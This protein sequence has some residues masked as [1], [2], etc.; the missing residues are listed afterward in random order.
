MNLTIKELSKAVSYAAML[1]KNRADVRSGIVTEAQALKKAK[2]L[3]A[4][5][6]L[7][8][9]YITDADLTT[10][11]TIDTNEDPYQ[12]HS[13]YFVVE[14][15]IDSEW[16]IQAVARL[17]H[18][19]PEKQDSSFQTLVH[20]DVNKES[21]ELIQ[22]VGLENCFEVSGLVKETGESTLA[23]MFLYREMWQYALMNGQK[24][25]LM[26]CDAG[27]YKRLSFLFGNAFQQIGKKSFFKGHD[28]IPALL[29]IRGSISVFTGKTKSRN[30]ATK[31][32]QHRLANFF[33]SG[34]PTE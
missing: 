34:L 3:H 30:P 19:H 11:G 24:L 22:L 10:E 28:V 31:L 26:S 16:R 21:R 2:Q 1:Q 27:L 25:W 5:V 14:R 18:F 4:K 13:E 33:L 8:R 29:D 17:I 9:G 12:E 7:S 15:L 32:L 23:V 6:F 20:Q